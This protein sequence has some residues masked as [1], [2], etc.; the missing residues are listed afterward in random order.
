MTYPKVRVVQVL[1]AGPGWLLGTP[2]YWEGP[3]G[4]YV[5]TW[6]SASPGRAY[7]LSGSAVAE[8]SKI[9]TMVADGISAESDDQALQL[10]DGVL[11][12]FSSTNIV[13]Q[14]FP[15]GILSISANGTTA[16]R[17]IL[18]A[19]LGLGNASRQAVPGV[20]HAFDATDLSHALWNSQQNAARDEV[21]NLAKFNT[22]VV[23]NGKVYLGTFSHQVAVYGPLPLGNT[24]PTVS[25][26][27]DQTIVGNE[28]ILLG[29]ASDDGLPKS[30]GAL[31]TTWVQVSG[32]RP[33]V[34]ETP[35]S[36]A[37][38]V[39][40]SAGGSYLLRFTASDGALSAESDVA[41]NVP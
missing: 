26:G 23:A 27:S 25:A 2:T 3:G 38:R 28:A 31:T 29:T 12:E 36:L 24:G 41:V 37:T 10:R 19:A 9:K 34:I 40:F 16:G 33:A 22:P 8:V 30:P 13:A 4:P 11:T 7:R 20:L 32:P 17:G 5:Y 6:C 1:W 14:G 39:R 18:W 21:G 15:G 35:H